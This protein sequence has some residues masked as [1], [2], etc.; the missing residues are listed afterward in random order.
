M[1]AAAISGREQTDERITGELAPVIASWLA[2]EG[3]SSQGDWNACGDDLSCSL[4][5]AYRRI[6]QLT[7]RVAKIT[8]A[9]DFGRSCARR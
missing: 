3:P 8:I 9:I 1:Y 4:A 7:E 6:E 5:S 2:I